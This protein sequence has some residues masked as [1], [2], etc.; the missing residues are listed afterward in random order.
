[1]TLWK[2]QG[3]TRKTFLLAFSF[4]PVIFI[5]EELLKHNVHNIQDVH[6]V[7]DIHECHVLA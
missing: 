4:T 2:V 3:M 6:N 1:M 5:I 7:N